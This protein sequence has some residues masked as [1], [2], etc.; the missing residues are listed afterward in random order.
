LTVPYVGDVVQRSR[1]QPTFCV[2]VKLWRNSDI[3]IWDLRISEVQIRGTSGTLLKGQASLELDFVSRAKRASQRPT[4]IGT[5]RARTHYI[6][7]SKQ[8]LKKEEKK[9]RKEK[10]MSFFELP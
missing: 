5:E 10:S 1:P 8:F 9:E 4:C 7:Y 6:F 2:S 3:P